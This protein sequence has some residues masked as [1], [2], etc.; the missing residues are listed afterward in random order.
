MFRNVMFNGFGLIDR[1]NFNKPI[2]LNYFPTIADTV[3]LQN[4][5]PL[6]GARC[7]SRSLGKIYH[8]WSIRF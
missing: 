7:Q 4:L 6:P 5:P 1:Y 8:L 2:C 3:L